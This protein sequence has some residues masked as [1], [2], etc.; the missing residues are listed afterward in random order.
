MP[1]SLLR[2]LP[3]VL[4]WD[5]IERIGGIAVTDSWPGVPKLSSFSHSEA[6]TCTSGRRP[7]QQ[8]NYLNRMSLFIHMPW[9]AMLPRSSTHGRLTAVWPAL[10]K[11]RRLNSEKE[12]AEAQICLQFQ[13]LDR[14][15]TVDNTRSFGKC[16][17]QSAPHDTEQSAGACSVLGE[18]VRSLATLLR[19][20]R[21]RSSE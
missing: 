14:T 10:I 4:K 16:Q 7:Q 12:L 19:A 20:P 3:K 21:L 13:F 11:L 8:V 15:F 5:E 9:T 17:N 1:Q 2:H 18:P 6:R